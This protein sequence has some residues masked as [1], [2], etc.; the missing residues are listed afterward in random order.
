MK[1]TIGRTTWLV[2]GLIALVALLMFIIPK[3]NVWS[4]GLKGKAELR[5]AEQNRQIKT[6]EARALKEAAYEL[7][8]ADTIRARGIALSNAI[9][10]ESLRNNEIYL[11]FLWLQALEKNEGDVIYIPTEGN[12]PIMEAGRFNRLSRDSLR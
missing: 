6:E 7:A 12:F 5:R 4:S 1:L 11:K 10:G 2:I 9:I 8:A 3:Y